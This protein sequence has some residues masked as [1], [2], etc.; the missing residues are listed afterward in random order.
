MS[1][2]FYVTTPIY[3]VNDVPHLGTAYT[4]IVADALARYHKLR[5]KKTRFLTGT[6]EHG[7]KIDREAQQRQQSP[8]QFVDEMSASFRAAWPKLLCQPDDFIRTTEPRHIERVQALWKRC[9]ANGDIYLGEHEGWYC[10]SCETFYP[11]KDLGEGRT[12]KTHGK[13]VE[14]MKEP[15]Y[16]FRLSKYA[17]RLIDLYER[18]PHMIQPEGRR[19]EILSFLREGLRDLSVSRTT[20]KWGVPV[21]GDEKHVMYVWFDALTNYL[22][23]LGDDALR[24]TFW[25]PDV[26]LVG[27]DIV[28]FHA[29][30]WP[31]FLMSA[32]FADDQLPRCVFAHGFLTI[33]G[34]KMSKSLRNVVEPVRLADYF[35]ADEV[36]YYL[37]REVAFGQDGDFSHQA[38][39]NRIRGELA[40]TLGNL[41]NRTLGAF[42][43]K[44]CDGKIPLPDPAAETEVDQVLRARARE[45][46]EE[47]ARAWDAYEPQRA[48]D[49]AMAL[50]MAG[51]KY[52][53]E[54]APWALAKQESQ[55][56]RL[57]VVLYHVMETL[58]IVS[59]LLWPVMPRKM[60]LL[61]AQL[62]LEP[63]TPREQLDRWPLAWGGLAPHQRVAPGAPL[64]RN[65]TKEDEAR[66][67]K[68]FEVAGEQPK[69]PATPA[70][71]AAAATPAAPAAAATTPVGVI[72]YGDFEKVELRLGHVLSAERIPKKDKL[73]KL[74]VDLGE[75]AGPRTIIAGIALA[76]APEQLVGKQLVIVANL[77]P[78]DFGKGLVSH[79]LL[80]ACGPSES[81]SIVTIEKPMP[82]GTRVT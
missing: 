30:Y 67:L 71:P 15:S 32:G 8:Q 16:F 41:L 38:L 68:D 50:A 66:M 3:Y 64:F 25:P 46:A 73:L 23:A 51:N 37:L 70:A 10:V 58:R 62:G 18:R 35:G 39:I 47:A 52:F 69:T 34:Q 13:P 4:T 55:R 29:I 63:T 22:S 33:N 79:G 31:A 77:A 20:F 1:D 28:R 9:A 45:A 36:R 6:D 75:P 7:L 53:D 24:H 61:R 21:P 80:L 27:K 76:Y 78:R 65:I 74:S 40:A 2:R 11:E 19:N 72:E 43:V 54:C 81:L 57:G 26:H 56:A 14:W 60:D 82:A 17:E 48:V 5:G 49:A 12:C 42:V 44:Y 59:L